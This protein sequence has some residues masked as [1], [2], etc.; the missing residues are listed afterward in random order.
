MAQ[1]DSAAIK[2]GHNL[3]NLI[4]NSTWKTQERFA[5]EAMFVDPTTVRRWLKNG[6]KD[7]TLIEEIC[8][9]F[10]IDLVDILK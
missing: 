7:L 6:I 10:N 1:V 9:V 3:K 8:R 4:K 2:V 5:C